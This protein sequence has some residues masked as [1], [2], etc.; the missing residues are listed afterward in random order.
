MSNDSTYFLVNSKH[1]RES[2]VWKNHCT[3]KAEKEKRCKKMDTLPNEKEDGMVI[4][5]SIT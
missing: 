5:L 4:G 3:A 1:S 2:Q